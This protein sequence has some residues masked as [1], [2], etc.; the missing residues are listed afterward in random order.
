MS[1]PT[2]PRLAGK[3]KV[4]TMSVPYY[5]Y[6][7]GMDAYW[8]GFW[9]DQQTNFA[10]TDRALVF[11]VNEWVYEPARRGQAI[12]KL[13][14]LDVRNPDAPT[15]SQALPATQECGRVWPGGRSDGSAWL[16][17]QPPQA[18]GRGEDRPT[19]AP[20]RNTATT[21]S[22]G[23]PRPTSGWAA[24]TSTRRAAWSAPGRARPAIACSCRR[25][26]TYRWVPLPQPPVQ[27]GTVKVRF[28]ACPWMRQIS[29]SVDPGR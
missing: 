5:R 4:P 26:L 18:G 6:W 8:G 9:F 1:N 28:T 24:T 15:V 17:H 2:Q 25:D 23:S 16:L 7:C 27:Q 19:V 29:R 10:T 20:S 14:F 3:V 12:N 13:I 22:A 11:Y 21:P